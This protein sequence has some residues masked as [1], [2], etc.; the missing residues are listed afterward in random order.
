MIDTKSVF[1]IVDRDTKISATIFLEMESAEQ[2]RQL[3]LCC[4]VAAHVGYPY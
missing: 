2:V 1:H 3:F 4:C